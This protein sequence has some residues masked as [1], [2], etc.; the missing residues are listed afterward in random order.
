MHVVC[1]AFD[2][3]Y[4]VWKCKIQ[5]DL[6]VFCS[7]PEGKKSQELLL[8]L[9]ASRSCPSRRANA[10]STL[11]ASRSGLARPRNAASAQEIRAHGCHIYACRPVSF[12]DGGRSMQDTSPGIISR[13]FFFFF[14]FLFA[15]E[16]HA[17]CTTVGH[18]ATVHRTRMRVILCTEQRIVAQRSELA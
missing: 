12:L 15:W 5:Q 13:S 8:F 1:F 4:L 7:S 17:P 11:S 3:S 6:L 9:H 2:R 14:F 16:D 10:R 18:E